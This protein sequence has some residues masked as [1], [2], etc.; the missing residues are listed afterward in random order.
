MGQFHARR[1]QHTAGD[2]GHLG[3]GVLVGQVDHL[4]DARLDDRLRALVAGKKPDVDPGARDPPSARVQDG[5]QFGVDDVGILGL[6]RRLA[7]AVPR[8]LVVGAAVGKAVV[9]GRDDPL[10]L[11]DDARADLGIRVLRPLCRQQRNAHK[12]FVPTDVTVSFHRILSFPE[13]RS[14]PQAFFLL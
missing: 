14:P 11:V 13:R 2:L 3:L 12:V 4:A 1:R 5:V 6:P 7:R 8:E 10:V 9:A